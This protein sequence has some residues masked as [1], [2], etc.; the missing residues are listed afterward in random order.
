MSSGLSSA[1][2]AFGEKFVDAEIAAEIA[3]REFGK[4]E[5][6][7][8]N[9]PQHAVG[10]AVVEFLVVVLAQIDGGVSDVVVFD[11]LGRPRIVVGRAPAPAEPKSAAL[12][13]RRPDRDFEP[14]GA[15]ALRSGTPTLFETTT[16]RANTGLPSSATT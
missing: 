2:Q 1:S 4:V 13:Q 9:R 3:A 16:S 14:A 10:E 11:D 12:A 8:Q 7:M 5:P 6:V 15:R